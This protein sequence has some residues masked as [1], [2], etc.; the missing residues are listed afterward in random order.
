M[1]GLVAVLRRCR[2]TH[3]VVLAIDLP[4]VTAA[5]LRNLVSMCGKEAGVVGMRSEQFEP[6]A[7]VYSEHCLSLAEECLSSGSLSLQEFVRRAVKDGLL[8][9]R[10]ITDAEELL[11]FN[12]NTPADIIAIERK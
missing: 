10:E 11:F 9:I 1:S 3:L 7:A 5:F 4:N 2:T 12:L 6:L 8:R